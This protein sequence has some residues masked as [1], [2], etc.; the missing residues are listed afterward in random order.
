MTTV[1]TS[2]PREDALPWQVVSFFMHVIAISSSVYRLWVRFR[3]HRT[4]WDDYVLFVPLIL[5]MFYGM[6]FWFFVPHELDASQSA[7]TVPSYLVILNSY[8]FTRFTFT[9]IVWSTRIVLALSLARL[10]PARTHA[11]ILSMLLVVIMLCFLVA[12]I[13]ISATTCRRKTALLLANELTDC[14]KSIAG[15][16]LEDAFAFAGDI[17]GDALL[18]ICP[19]YWFWNVRLPTKERRL[20]LLAFCGNMLTLLFAITFVILIN[21]RV[22]KTLADRLLIQAGMGHVEAAISLFVCNFAVISTSIYRLVQ[23]MRRNSES[24]S[25]NAAQNAFTRRD[26]Y[27]LTQYYTSSSSSS[28]RS[29]PPMTLTEISSFPSESQRESLTESPRPS[30]ASV[31]TAFVAEKRGA[32]EG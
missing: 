25:S 13:L 19:L 22:G 15:F 9:V 1:L 16:A 26:A 3:I 24:G 14:T 2:I 8:W 31:K 29:Q 18:V 20:I 30:L 11:R 5:D 4:W 23:K 12:T 7:P 32:L 17:I 21:L 28:G 6:A 10:F 27:R